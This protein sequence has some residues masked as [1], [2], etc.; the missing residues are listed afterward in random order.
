[1][2]MLN[3]IDGDCKTLRIMH[4]RYIVHTSEKAIVREVTMFLCNLTQAV[5]DG[6]HLNEKKVYVTT[7]VLKH[8]YD[9]KPAV[10]YDFI[11]DNLHLV[12]KYPDSI[13]KNKDGKRGSLC[14][15]KT[16]ENVKLLATVE[17]NQSQEI[18]LIT[19]FPTKEN[20]LK[21]CTVLWNWRDGLL[22]S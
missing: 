14:F 9:S 1:M 11:L 4:K 12:V 2:D 13:L 21:N 15:V 16:I 3:D 6:I 20:Y 5:S 19:S 10:V 8:L 18:F 22:S 17:I 7:K